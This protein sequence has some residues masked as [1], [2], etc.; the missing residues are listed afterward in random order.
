MPS[1]MPSFVVTV[2]VAMAFVVMAFVASVFV[3]SR[4]CRSLRSRRLTLSTRL[5]CRGPQQTR[6]GRRVTQEL[7]RAEARD[8]AEAW[9]DEPL[10][11]AARRLLIG[12]VEAF[13]AR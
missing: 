13:A 6:G 4:C 9:L 12:A 10:A 5:Q 8:L 2:F 11:P 7:D 1:S 3:T